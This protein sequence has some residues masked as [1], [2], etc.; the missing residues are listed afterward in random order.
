MNPID[1]LQVPK[2][3][4][5]RN[6]ETN[7][8]AFHA[9]DSEKKKKRFLKMVI[10]DYANPVCEINRKNTAIEKKNILYAKSGAELLVF[11]ET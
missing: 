9:C 4:T 1:K 10:F 6:H 8:V 5:K 7:Y 3:K 11:E 2:M